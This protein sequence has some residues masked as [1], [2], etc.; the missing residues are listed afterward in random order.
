MV[1]AAYAAQLW[2]STGYR[3][4][5]TPVNGIPGGETAA[6]ARPVSSSTSALNASVAVTAFI[7]ARGYP[8]SPMPTTIAV[9]AA[10]VRPAPVLAA[11]RGVRKCGA[12]SCWRTD[13]A[14]RAAAELRQA[15]VPARGRCR[16]Q[17]CGRQLRVTDDPGLLQG[18]VGHERPCH[19]SSRRVFELRQPRLRAARRASG[20]RGRPAGRV[21]LADAECAARRTLTSWRCAPGKLAVA[22]TD[23]GRNLPAHVEDLCEQ[24]RRPR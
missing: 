11:R 19:R 8:P 5:D 1:L 16:A 24:H 21:A 2:T 22:G 20:G 15:G 12:C 23:A 6:H 9:T 14:A 17:C 4:P 7:I 3:R 18:N 13:R 10:V